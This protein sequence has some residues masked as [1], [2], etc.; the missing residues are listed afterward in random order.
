MKSDWFAI[1]KLADD[2]RD[3]TYAPKNGP[4]EVRRTGCC[5]AEAV[6]KAVGLIFELRGH[7][8]AEPSNQI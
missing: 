1:A 2:P 4:H 5:P 7:G 6:W 8:N 3:Q